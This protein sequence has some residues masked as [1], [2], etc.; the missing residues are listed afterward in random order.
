MSIQRA[1]EIT[2]DVEGWLSDKEAEF[3]YNQA[4]KCAG[5]GVI[6][7]IG[8]WKGRS[9]SFMGLGSLDGNKVPIYAIDPHYSVFKEG[10]DDLVVT[11][12][13]TTFNEFKRNIKK[14]GV[15]KI[16]TPIVAT[17]EEANKSWDKPIELLWI[18]GDHSYEAR[19][20]DFQLWS[21][22]LVDGG[23]I[24]MHDSFVKDGRIDPSIKEDIYHSKFFY[25]QGM[26]DVLTYATKSGQP[27]GL[28]KRFRGLCLDGLDELRY[29]LRKLPWPFRSRLRTVGLKFFPFLR[30]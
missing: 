1:K 28:M 7:E 12:E 4:K 23:V 20:K 26:A 21:P 30:R 22:F 6:V 5:R 9:A 14:T 3:L 16:V 19:K 10:K 13:V 15:D 17:S 24:A 29:F 27:I 18:D 8:S 2:K 11:N 25:D